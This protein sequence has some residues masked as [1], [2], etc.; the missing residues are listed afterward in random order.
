MNELEK[1]KKIENLLEDAAEQVQPNLVFKADLEEKLREAHKPRKTFAWNFSK[2]MPTL[3]SLTVLGALVAFMLW[4]FQSVEPQNGVGSGPSFACPVTLPNGS[5]PPNTTLAED[6]YS[7]GNGELWTSLWPQGKIVME[8]QNLEADGSYSMKW[9]YVRGVEGALTIE[10]RRLDAEAEPLRAFINDGY[11]ESGL[12]ILALIFPTTGCW[13][14]TAHVG[15]SSLTFVTEV[16]SGEVTPQ[17]NVEP[18]IVSTPLEQNAYPWRGTTLQLNAEL[19]Q[20]PA[21]MTI[22]QTVADAPATVEDVRVLAQVFGMNGEI[23]SAPGNLPGTT[24]YMMVDGNRQLFVRSKNT[25]HYVPNH[26][27]HL[28]NP[29]FEKNENAESSIAEFMQTY[30]LGNNYKVEYAE[31]YNGY[32]AMPLDL[33]GYPLQ[34]GYGVAS[35]Y[36][37]RFTEDGL[38][39]VETSLVGYEALGTAA[40]ISSEEAW[41]KV[42]NATDGMG[43]QESMFMSNNV[44]IQSWARQYPLNETL[45]VFGFISSTGK[46]V[47]GNPPLVTLDAISMTGNIADIAENLP[48]TFVEARGQF[49]EEN[50]SRRFNLESWSPYNSYEEGIVGTL[51]R[52]GDAVYVIVAEG[53]K[54]LLPD[55]PSDLVLPS[56]ELFLTGV[57]RGD[58]F[59]WKSID[60]RSFRGG[61]GGGGGGFYKLNLSGTP[62]PFPTMQPTPVLQIEFKS[63]TFEALPGIVNTTIY[64]ED[65]GTQRAEYTFIP[66]ENVAVS[67][68][69]ILEGDGLEEL[70]KYNNLPVLISGKTT[71]VNEV[72]VTIFNVERFEIP[73]LDLK[74]QIFKGKTQPKIINGQNV[75]LYTTEEGVSYIVAYNSGY[76]PDDIGMPHDEFF[77][78][79]GY[80]IPN[81]TFSEYPMLRMFGTG[82]VNNP[83]TGEE[84]EYLVTSDQPQVMPDNPSASNTTISATLE[85]V[86]LVYYTPDPRFSTVEQMPQ[87]QYIQP[88]WRFFGRYADGTV[89]EIYV[90]ALTQEFLSPE[91]EYAIPPG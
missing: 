21:E 61:G 34:L 78:I 58:V 80:A 70:Q 16:V 82:M 63:E 72:G 29:F 43:M 86:E 18:E 28:K 77:Y 42:L 27:A 31:I 22:Y 7:Y 57:T 53:P 75:L 9:G 50:G 17:P 36:L 26:S 14:V 4:I 37:F 13:E 87:P 32:Y 47:D 54:L 91:A 10:G 52:E 30:N 85:R 45:T 64:V 71:L 12:Q 60:N 90:Q 66:T 25:F 69:L 2:V 79:E 15:N 67:P 24:G 11:G 81:E 76:I 65:D 89:F 23:Y 33:N 35:G 73:H 46:S 19:P 38:V 44:D 8:E 49:I 39:G 62:I 59:E 88:V 83:V 41:Q 5:L 6:P 84:M 68:Y 74:I 40:I 1:N 3:T 51:T 48:N 56:E 20:M 55:A